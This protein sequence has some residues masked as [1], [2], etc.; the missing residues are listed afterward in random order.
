MDNMTTARL[1]AISL[2][3]RRFAI[4]VI[5]LALPGGCP[6]EFTAPPVQNSQN[7]N[8]SPPAGGSGQAPA[9]P[10]GLSL[11]AGDGRVTLAWG[12]VSGATG[13]RVRFR[14]VD[15]D[16]VESELPAAPFV[17]EPL[18][19]GAWYCYEV[20]AFNAAGASAPSGAGC[21]IP[22][23]PV[24]RI[25]Y[26]DALISVADASLRDHL[27]DLG[28]RF[29]YQY[30]SDLTELAFVRSRSQSAIRELSG[31]GQFNAL[32]QLTLANHE[33][34]DL[35]PLAGLTRL[36]D[37]NLENNRIVDLTALGRL[38]GLANVNLARNGISSVGTLPQRLIFLVW[39]NLDMNRISDFG[40]FSAFAGRELILDAQNVVGDGPFQVESLAAL[41]NLQHLSLQSNP[42][43]SCSG[44]Q[45]VF[46]A[47]GAARVEA[48]DPS[49]A[50]PN[51]PTLGCNCR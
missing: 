17:H 12:L 48:Q 28:D 32:R 40:Q 46:D 45:E 22:Q 27:R 1:R 10:D 39:L 49:G 36:T 4:L 15:Q 3:L 21:A 29:G 38:S 11:I 14:S 18:V 42:G 34:V 16:W 30:S 23:P 9:R 35:A 50:C 19:N 25:P 37:L 6:N 26:A 8:E 20:V 13:Y 41:T 44:L 47:L 2:R 31:I 24:S 5:S 43:L 7:S 33:I 51:Q